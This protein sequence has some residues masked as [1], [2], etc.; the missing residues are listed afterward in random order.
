MLLMLALSFGATPV[1]GNV[2]FDAQ[3]R[4]ILESRCYECH[5]EKKQKGRLRLDQRTSV[6]EPPKGKK[7]RVVAGKP[8]ES[9]LYTLTTLEKDDPDI[10]PAE[11][12]PLTAEQTALLRAWIEQG[13]PWPEDAP[14][15]EPKTT[16]ATADATGAGGADDLTLPPI[17]E[18]ERAAEEQVMAKIGARGGLALRVAAN[19]PAIETNFSLLGA[20]AAD[21]DLALLAG[22]EKNLVWLN[23]SRT[24]VTDAGVATLSNFSQLRRLNLSNTK[25]TDAALASLSGLE[26]LEY[27]NLYGTAVT[28]AGIAAL[29]AL[30]RLR[31]VFVWQTAVSEDGA[32]VLAA[33]RAG[34]NV[35]R[36]VYEPAKSEPA[37]ELAADAGG[38]AMNAKCPVSGADVDASVVS[39]F[40]GQTIAF[41][42]ANCRAQF[43]K[44]PASFVAKIPEFASKT[45]APA[46]PAADAQAAT[47]E[48][49]WS[50]K[51]QDLDGND[52][53]LA[54]LRGRVVLVVNTA[55][56]GR[57][58]SQYAGL[59]SLEKTYRD[60]GF[61]V[62]A[63][64]SDDFGGQE[65]GDSRSIAQFAR[66]QFG[67]EF[68][69][70]AKD[71]VASGSASPAAKLFAKLAK[72]S[73]HPPTWN[74]TK[75]LV[76]KDGRTV[77]HFA[78]RVDP[79]GKR[80]REAIEAALE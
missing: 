57:Y 71:S 20:A 34:I 31:D 37:P 58:A 8:D 42:C 5:G 53:D 6:F 46:A 74:F 2:D 41:C 24:S 79:S 54:T 29:A 76:A 11:G 17:T 65:P 9:S 67:V 49:L 3:I 30:P 16:G 43:E 39:T 35:D 23:L 66:K 77:E 28:D 33:A 32:K 60:R 68:T 18:E 62:L 1:S 78:P 44:D 52:V 50:G 15:P 4:P 45:A 22:L 61:T 47:E 13:A 48:E 21:A 27:L 80:I 59:Q 36:G 72:A 70:L 19:T 63:I 25:I 75:Y 69:L 64:P 38:K 51:F 26:R 73:G 55:S 14:P 12:D 10:M 40:E 56:Q 7:P